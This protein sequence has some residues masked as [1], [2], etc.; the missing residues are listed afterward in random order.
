[1]LRAGE[2][3]Q[4]EFAV[5]DAFFRV[6]TPT[7]KHI[8]GASLSGVAVFDT[9]SSSASDSTPQNDAGIGFS[10][11]VLAA[12]SYSAHL[13]LR[14][15]RN[16]CGVVSDITMTF[17]NGQSLLLSTLCLTAS[18]PS[19]VRAMKSSTAFSAREGSSGGTANHSGMP[20]TS[21]P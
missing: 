9:A 19:V 18:N 11:L 15:S 14:H 7:W 10:R 16:A 5:P 8:D 3:I 4:N 2:E 17:L 13:P 21:V 20:T 6:F 1:M 12:S